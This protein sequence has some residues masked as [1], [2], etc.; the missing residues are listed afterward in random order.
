MNYLLKPLVI[1]IVLLNSCTGGPNQDSEAAQV[2]TEVQSRADIT[3]PVSLH[4]RLHVANTQLVDDCGRSVQLSGISHFWHTWEGKEHWNGDVVTWLRDDWRVSVV[5]AP[6]ACHPNVEGDYLTAPEAS[7]QQLRDL[8]EGAIKQGVYVIVDFHAHNNYADEAI[9]VLGTIAKDYGQHPN[10]IYAIWNEPVG[11]PENPEEM[12]AE[13]KAY[14]AKVIPAIRKYDPENIIVV[15][16][17]HYDQFP[18]VAAK[19]MLTAQDLGGLTTS[20]IMYDLHAY[21]GQH[22][23]M[24]RDRAN[25]ALAL[26]LP[27]IMTEVGRVAVN[28]GPD[29]PIDSMSFNTWMNWID[30]HG[31]SFTKWSLSYR[32]EVSSSLLSSASP[33]GNWTEADLSPEGK[34]N[35]NFFRTRGHKFYASKP[36]T[37]MPNGNSKVE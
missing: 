9:E 5:R 31:I 11:S 17:P 26:G 25:V 34:W 32:N 22:K 3:T 28:W 1:F 23:E 2:L 24:I 4:G 10:L 30:E 12:W 20:H 36:C 33:T 21:A 35:R 18:D 7:M 8:V 19:D 29:N 15:P 14:A 37:Q 13:I 27:I 16:T 6:L